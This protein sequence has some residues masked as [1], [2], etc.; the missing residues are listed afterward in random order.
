MKRLSY[1]L[2]AGVALMPLVAQA[3]T[4]EEPAG[5]SNAS[6]GIVVTATRR[7]EH[8]QDVPVSVTAL[9]AEA[10]ESQQIRN[11]QD[12]FGVVPAV[13]LATGVGGTNELQ[14]GI[15]G[16]V[17]SQLAP[18]VDMSV[19][20]YVDDVYIAR[21]ATAN[22]AFIDMQRVEVL[23]GPQGTLFGR[24]TIGGAFNITTHRPEREFGGSVEV[25]YGDYNQLG[26]SGVLNAPLSDAVAARF[27]YDHSEH[28]GFGRSSFLNEEMSSSQRDYARASLLF[29]PSDRLEVTLIGDYFI[30]EGD[31]QFFRLNYVNPAHAVGAT[32]VPYAPAS[33]GGTAPAGT[34]DDW[35]NHAGF[36]PDIS[37]ESYSLTGIAVLDMEWATLRSITSYRNTET[38]RRSD[39]DATPLPTLDFLSFPQDSD[40]VSQELQLFGQA[41]GGQL[42][43]IVGAYYFREGGDT[44]TGLARPN[45]TQILMAPENP[46]F[47]NQS[48][49]VFGQATFALSDY[50]SITGGVRRVQDNREASYRQFIGDLATGAV[51][52]CLLPPGA[53]VGGSVCLFE[54]EEISDYFTPWTVGLEFQPSRDALLYFNVSRGYRSG[55]FPPQ[56]GSDVLSLEPFDPESL[57][58]YELGGK[59]TFL[60]GNLIANFALY[61]SLYND[62]QQNTNLL[63]PVTMTTYSTLTNAGNAELDGGELE[64]AA[65]IGELRLTANASF[66]DAEF[67]KGV[68]VGLP[69]LLTPD[70]T[71]AFAVDYPI[72]IGPGTLNLHTDYNWRSEVYFYSP[73]GMTPEQADAVS[74]DAYGLWNARLSYDVGRLTF[75]VFG[76]NLT[77]EVY[78][79][80]TMNFVLSRGFNTE[81]AGDPRT[82]GVSLRYRF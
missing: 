71:Y 23:R 57:T 81:A 6:E 44:T 29:S 16:L 53:G 49:S 42:D 67:V 68:G 40:Q 58:S 45:P 34:A 46:N 7:E 28:E 19:G 20:I 47:E 72:E 50:W 4:V 63:N 48:I 39:L 78:A 79:A 77:D 25:Q 59:F 21:P 54:P 13:S 22:A 55:G 75:G 52:S 74:Q 56:V 8:L 30:S 33:I 43:W 36:N 3:Q 41:M 31:S 61:H 5:A 32:L 17:P 18:T 2:A 24:N 38:E 27:V 69:Y 26:F 9:S 70:S 51:L 10:L 66:I 1:V 12:L 80:R 76:K 60:D 62:V 11:V 35:T 64:L 82:Y 15:R 14:I 73:A 37:T 65:R